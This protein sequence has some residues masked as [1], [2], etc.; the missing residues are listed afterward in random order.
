VTC[1][2]K[3]KIS[4]TFFGPSNQQE[5]AILVRSTFENTY[6][7]RFFFSIFI[8]YPVTAIEVSGKGSQIFNLCI[9][10]RAFHDLS[11]WADEKITCSII[12]IW[13]IREP[14]TIGMQYNPGS[15]G[16]L[17]KWYSLACRPCCQA[18]LKP[19]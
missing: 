1:R 11:L 16:R 2:G 12:W 18:L 14:P 9:L 19:D 10:F 3:P 17:R 6:G 4:Q 8:G 13:L 15:E 7:A 5:P